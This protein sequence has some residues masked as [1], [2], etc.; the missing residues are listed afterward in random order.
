MNALIAMNLI[1]K[2]AKCPY[3]GKRCVGNGEG[4]IVIDDDKFERTCKCGW[5]IKIPVSNF[6]EG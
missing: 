3:C 2:Y 6:A 1:Q 5:S 4:T